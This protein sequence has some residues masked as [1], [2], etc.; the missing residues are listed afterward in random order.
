VPGA[1]R[2]WLQQF[3]SE[4]GIQTGAH[5]PIALPYLEAYSYLGHR[6]GEFPRAVGASEEIL[7][8]PIFAEVTE[9]QIQHVAECIKAFLSAN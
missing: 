8:L 9:T 3:L 6:E 1:K 4:R 7:P 2:A 5:Y